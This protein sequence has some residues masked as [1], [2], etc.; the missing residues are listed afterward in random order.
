MQGF[1][2]LKKGFQFLETHR[3]ISFTLAILWTLIIIIGVSMPGKELPK[4]NLF[5]HFD[6]VVHFTFFFAFFILWKMVFAHQEKSSR[7][8]IAIAIAFGFAIE[9]YQLHLV[10]GRSF[11]V[12]DGI[13]DSLGAVFGFL[14]YRYY[15][16]V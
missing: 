15:L 2:M 8:I 10:T 16:K 5:D 12:W 13:F 11:D 3:K 6:K 7:M 14:F 1:F 4:L 9:Y